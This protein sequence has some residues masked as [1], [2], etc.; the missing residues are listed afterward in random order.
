MC[1]RLVVAPLV[2]LLF[3]ASCAAP[4]PKAVANRG[5]EPPNPFKEPSTP[6]VCA[7]PTEKSSY[8]QKHTTMGRTGGRERN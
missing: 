3:L 7:A 5:C 6:V 4:E 1:L 8:T 2:I